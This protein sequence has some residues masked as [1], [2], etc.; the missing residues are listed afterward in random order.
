V[1]AHWTI[2]SLSGFFEIPSI[3]INNFTG[4]GP[5]GFIQLDSIKG[6]KTLITSD[7]KIDIP[8]DVE[9]LNCPDLESFGDIRSIDG[10]LEVEYHAE[11]LTSLGNIEKIGRSITRVSFIR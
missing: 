11:K 10:Y 9:I 3:E 5:D 6:L 8:A 4:I 2:E 7:K 1:L